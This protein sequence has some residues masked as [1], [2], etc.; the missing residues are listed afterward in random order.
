[1]LSG[2]CTARI[3][4][5]LLTS[6]SLFLTSRCPPWLNKSG[7]SRISRLQLEKLRL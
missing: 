5:A 7:W 6:A 2:Y 1:M 4:R 3:L